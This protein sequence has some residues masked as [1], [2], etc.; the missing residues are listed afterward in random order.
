M[1]PQYVLQ[2]QAQVISPPGQA[3]PFD[4]PNVV[5][6]IAAR[7]SF[8]QLPQLTDLTGDVEVRYTLDNSTPTVSSSLYGGPLALKNVSRLYIRALAFEPD[9]APSNQTV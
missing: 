9:S 4:C 2:T 8:A 6:S 1:S 5:I 7:P 3:V